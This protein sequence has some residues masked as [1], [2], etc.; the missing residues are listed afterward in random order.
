MPRGLLKG[1]SAREEEGYGVVGGAGDC[2]VIAAIAVQV[3]Q[4]KP[5]GVGPP[6]EVKREA[7][8]AG[9]AAG[10]SAGQVARFSLKIDDDLRRGPQ[11]CAPSHDV[12]E[13]VAVEVSDETVAL[14]C[15]AGQQELEVPGLLQ[16]A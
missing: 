4:R 13:S 9:Q 8:T 11:L 14:G 16:W 6:G 5:M 1:G 2:K 10:V 3:S 12:I 15:R 7:G